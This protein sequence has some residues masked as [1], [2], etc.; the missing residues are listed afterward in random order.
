[1]DSWLRLFISLS[2][3]GSGAFVLSFFITILWKDK[4]NAKWHYWNRKLSLFLFIIP[5]FMIPGFLMIEKSNSQ[6]L[7]ANDV[8]FQC[9]LFG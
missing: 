1:M 3:A 9:L 8:P 7:L 6:Y 2:V 4:M 5:I